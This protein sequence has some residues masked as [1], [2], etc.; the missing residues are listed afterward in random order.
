MPIRTVRFQTRNPVVAVALLLLVLALLAAL[1]TVGIAV[2]GVLAVAGGAGLLA[3]RAL[4]GRLPR[5]E[6]PRLDRSREVF[7]PPPNARRLPPSEP[8]DAPTP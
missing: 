4:R 8:P 5:A 3:R 6:P 2:A 1:F 7:A